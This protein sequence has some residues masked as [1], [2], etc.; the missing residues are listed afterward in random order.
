M[1]TTFVN[2]HVI[3]H[4][5]G[6]SRATET[7]TLT[8]NVSRSGNTVTLS[9]LNLYVE[10]AYAMS[11]H[12]YSNEY[13]VTNSRTGTTRYSTTGTVNYN[14]DLPSYDSRPYKTNWSMGNMSFDV[15]TTDTSKSFWL[16][17]TS[18]EDN[19]VEFTVYFPSG[20]SAPTGLSGSNL[21][22]GQTSFTATVSV[23]GWGGAG[24]A[25][26]RYRELQVRTYNA[27]T[28]ATPYRYN[29][30]TGNTLSSSITVD[31]TVN[32]PSSDPLTL[33]PNTLYTI[34]LY[35]SNGT[36]N[37]GSVRYTNATTLPPTP[38]ISKTS[39]ASTSA[40]FS[41]SVPNQGGSYNMSLQYT[42]NGGATWTTAATL[43]GSGTKS[44][45]FTVSGLSGYTDYTIQCRITTTA[46]TSTGNS[47]SFK[48]SAI[49]PATPVVTNVQPQQYGVKATVTI[50]NYG[51]PSSEADRYIELEGGVSGGSTLLWR[52]DLK[53]AVLTGSFEVNNESGGSIPIFEPNSNYSYRGMATN[54]KLTSYSSWVDFTCLPPTPSACSLTITGTSTATLSI[55][56]PSM[57]YG[58]TVTAYYKLNSGSWTSAGTITENETITKSLTGLSAGTSYTPTVKFTNV[59][60]D[61]P[62]Y[63]GAAATTWKSPATPTITNVSIGTDS[64]T[65]TVTVAN[66]GVPDLSSRW[67]ELEVAPTNAGSTFRYTVAGNTLS[68]TLTV[69]NSSSISPS[70]A[71]L[72]L[73]PNT[74]Y[75]YAGAANNT[76]VLS[77]SAWTAF[78]TK[79]AQPTASIVTTHPHD[80]TFRISAPSQ[81]TAATM[82]A[83]YKVGSGEWT[84][85]GTITQ[86]GHVDVSLTNLTPNETYN[87][88]VKVSNSTGDSATATLEI[89]TPGV[90]YGSVEDLSKSTSKLYGSVNG[91][92]KRIVKLYGSENGVTKRVI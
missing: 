23:T 24:D 74:Q 36:M 15:G 9:G 31:N 76:R 47:I 44:G 18:I 83:Y 50:A 85:A 77:R 60:G 80:A 38:S 11:V 87:V 59:S 48:T 1:A 16:R 51:A 62:T 78:I 53:K 91:N 19:P 55:S 41:Y 57:G 25:S 7:V 8:G 4:L 3:S 71:T 6:E 54:T 14:Y 21:V 88:T 45:S 29:P 2:S 92:S 39:V 35:A 70:G 33:V 68:S 49:A 13:F 27:S 67:L 86:G 90:F 84:S 64:I 34:G 40:T 17:C 63:T 20:A 89:L 73:T 75:Y 58:S 52:Y 82:T 30:V 42:I 65:G 46:G 72:T 81:G 10:I 37:T 69:N 32:H 56:C 28:M 5:E 79:P 43:T 22:A 12:G 61:S 26:S 66:Y